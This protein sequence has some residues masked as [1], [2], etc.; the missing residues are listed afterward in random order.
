VFPPLGLFY[1]AAAIQDEHEVLFW[2]ACLDGDDIPDG[3]DV[4]GITVNIT[5]V[6][7]VRRFLAEHK[8]RN[9]QA[10]YVLG[11]PYVSTAKDIK[12]DGYDLVV[13]GEGER[14]FREYLDSG[15]RPAH[16][17][18]LLVPTY[19]IDD[20]AFPAR[21]LCAVER[22]TYFLSRDAGGHVGARGDVPIGARRATSLVSSRGCP[23]RCA[24]CSRTPWDTKTKFRSVDNIMEEIDEI[25]G[26]GYTGLMIYDDTFTLRKERVRS[27]CRAIE[28]YGLLWK[29]FARA[30]RITPEMA[31]DMSRAGCVEVSIGVE[32]GSQRILDV[33]GKG[34]TVVQ[35]TM[36]CK[37]CKDAGISVRA[38]MILGLPG[39]THET[40][41]ETRAWLDDAQP[42][43]IGL[44]PL[45]PYPGSRIW[46]NPDEFDIQINLPE[47]EEEWHY[48]GEPGK[49]NVYVST[50][51]LTSEEIGQ[52]IYAIE[53]DWGLVEDGG[54]K[55][56]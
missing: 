41:A 4:Y 47:D 8:P 22:Y 24:F 36:A 16:G 56:T 38:F 32:S 23:F 49:Y 12:I 19:P 39:E 10:Q 31:L 13:L 2:D 20:I 51:G 48:R 34:T 37:A 33:V 44:G 54:R 1:I 52:Y 21:R 55:R 42:D 35:N 30:D 50:S 14:A 5:E 43:S 46:K 17:E 25:V 26:M 3:Y 18:G 27:F 40:V 29:C 53:K 15:A 9:P 7:W 6:P 45:I 11:G 28:S